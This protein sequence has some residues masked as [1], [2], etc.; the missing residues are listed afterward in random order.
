MIDFIEE[1]K[2]L[3]K[4][5]LSWSERFKHSELDYSFDV[6]N[7][8]YRLST[9]YNQDFEQGDLNLIYN[10][11]DFYSDA[12]KHD[13]KEIAGNYSTQMAHLDIKSIL[14]ELDKTEAV[15]LPSEVWNRLKKL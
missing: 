1:L 11:L 14:D 3:L 4:R 13:F 12:I 2:A 8:I 9:K 5:T 10:L 6:D 15:S 7:E